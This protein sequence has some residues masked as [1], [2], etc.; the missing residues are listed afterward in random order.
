M[1]KAC[2]SSMIH[3]RHNADDLVNIDSLV[4]EQLGNVYTCDITEQ[5]VLSD[6]TYDITV[7]IHCVLLDHITP[8][9]GVHV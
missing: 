3:V 6:R 4:I 2:V 7:S 5:C 1:W 8:Q 9:A